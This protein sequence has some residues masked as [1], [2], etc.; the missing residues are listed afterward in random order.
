MG[1]HKL[2]LIWSNFFSVY[3]DSGVPFLGRVVRKEVPVEAAVPAQ[4]LRYAALAQRPRSADSKIVFLIFSSLSA[5]L[6]LV[7]ESLIS[8]QVDFQ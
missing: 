2:K 5:F 6:Q 1:Q 8:V 4:S 3:L 7:F